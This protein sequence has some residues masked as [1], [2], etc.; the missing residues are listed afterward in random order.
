MEEE[1]IDVVNYDA[2]SSVDVEKF[3]YQCDECAWVGRSERS[4]NAHK[5]HKHSKP[6]TS[7]EIVK[8]TRGR[9][10]KQ[11]ENSFEPGTSADDDVFQQRVTTKQLL[12]GRKRPKTTVDSL[13][14]SAL[15]TDREASRLHDLGV[16]DEDTSL[17]DYVRRGANYQRI[18]Q[19]M[20]DGDA[21]ELVV[22]EEVVIDNGDDNDDEISMN[23]ELRGRLSRRYPEKLPER[24]T[25]GDPAGKYNCYIAECDWRGGY[26]S[27]RMDHMKAVHPDWKMPSRFLLERISKDGVYIDPEEYIPPFGCT[28]EGCNWRGNYRASRSAH[29]RKMH[30]KEHADKKKNAPGYNSNGNYAC[31]IQ[32]CTWRGYSR[33]TRSQH[34]KKAH[35]GWR[36]EDSRV[37][38]S[39][40]CFYCKNIFN[41]YDQFSTHISNHGGLGIAV[42]EVFESKIQF[43]EWL[44]SIEKTYSITF[45]RKELNH[46]AD[47]I[48]DEARSYILNCNCTGQK[49]AQLAMDAR[50]HIYTNLGYLKRRAIQLATRS[51]N[52]C[53]VHLEIQEDTSF[54]PI[55]AKG[56]LEHTGHRFG[57]PLLRMTP[58]DRQL[59]CDVMAWQA[60]NSNFQFM[61]MDVVE[62]LTT[63]EGFMMDN[64]AAVETLNLIDPLDDD[65]MI[66]LR[67]IIEQS[68]PTCFFS[69]DFSEFEEGHISF[70]YMT[71]EM[72]KLYKSLGPKGIV[73]IDSIMVQFEDIEF[74][75]YVV[76]LHDGHLP[77][78]ALYYLTTD[79]ETAP[80]AILQQLALLDA[81]PPKELMADASEVWVDMAA[82]FFKED[83]PVCLIS[84]WNLMDFWAAKVEQYV[85]NEFDIF[86]L[87][88]A[89][90]RFIRVDEVH[91]MQGYIVELQEALFECGYEQ[92]SEFFDYQ[93]T[94]PEYVKR[95]S[96]LLRSSFT[97]H[98]HPTPGAAAKTL[99]EMYL[100]NE[101][102][103]RCDQWF[104]HLTKRICDFN[105]V[106]VTQTYTLRP[107]E[108]AKKFFYN[109]VTTDEN[110]EV[111]PVIQDEHQEDHTEE[112]Q[113][114]IYEEEIL[115]GTVVEE[116]IIQIDEVGEE[117]QE[118]VEEIEE[119]EGDVT[120]QEEIIYEEIE[121]H[122]GHI[123]VELQD[124]YEGPPNEQEGIARKELE[125]CSVLSAK[126]PPHRMHLYQHKSPEE[127][128]AST[129]G[130]SPPKRV[131][132]PT[133][134]DPIARRDTTKTV[135]RSKKRKEKFS[136]LRDCPPAV[137]QALAAHAISYDGRKKEQRPYMFLPS[138]AKMAKSNTPAVITPNMKTYGRSMPKRMTA[139]ELAMVQQQ[140][141]NQQY[142][143]LQHSREDQQEDI[144]SGHEMQEIADNYDPSSEP[145]PAYIAGDE[146]QYHPDDES[147][148]PE[149]MVVHHE[150][151][152]MEHEPIDDQ[153]P[154]SSASLY[155]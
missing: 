35:P 68:D 73:V 23:Y 89:L 111:R 33:S 135:I 83:T 4:L 92:L 3:E 108:T 69:I 22:G 143:R 71:M 103:E 13:D 116:E 47:V 151:V 122:E 48:D 66:S 117:I 146:S 64:F 72:Q 84:E 153:Q 14:E 41:S 54:G 102:I 85:G 105:A 96:P 9:P 55:H 20:I 43:A 7:E 142:N 106:P 145:V 24:I 76:I 88:A 25:M 29:M 136:Q 137:M 65:P 45:E 51:K 104:A 21:S 27:L 70:G 155:R 75:Q 77:K 109:Q 15:R 30:P 36:P 60:T 56:Y 112:Y 86:C 107:I 50:N 115:T 130:A 49:G 113:D 5:R 134:G 124:E 100:S 152:Q 26:R 128:G 148:A 31:H 78:C 32:A 110:G 57:T 67:T 81:N 150:E 144:S 28:V 16:I 101:G 126:V 46:S 131:V 42:D 90:R 17:G 63:Y 2:N 97:S 53:S 19:E 8:R 59:Y 39:L 91:Q 149:S 34:L 129:S 93:L 87:V 139:E 140:R 118:V 121:E 138:E 82:K 120:L 98:A 127:T 125:N 74:T 1:E 154:C 79:Y 10:R 38:M 62:K 133:R 40:S 99:R 141:R 123:D 52:D 37:M 95:W 12:G 94:D 58:M 147:Y 114:V 11:L 119:V 6:E 18:S 80:A 132:V 44:Q 61:A